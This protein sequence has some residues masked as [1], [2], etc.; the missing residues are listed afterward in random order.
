MRRFR[1]LSS[2]L[3]LLACLTVSAQGDLGSSTPEAMSHLRQARMLTAAG[4]LDGAIAA[5]RAALAA[6]PRYTEARLQ[7]ASAFRSRNQLDS[8]ISQYRRALDLY[9]RNID[10]HQY[11]AS[12]YLLQGD[13][14]S[15][16]GQYKE[17]LRHYPDYP[18]AYLGLAQVYF[19][20]EDYREAVRYSESAMR[21]YLARELDE[22][23]ASARM[24]AG[25]AYLALGDADR[26]LA[27]FKA[28]K[29]HYEGMAFYDYYL[30]L[31]YLDLGNRE[32]S[33][34]YLSSAAQKGYKLPPY[35][36]ERLDRL[37]NGN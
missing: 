28:S 24:L 18:E 29:R 31:A 5:C 1:L 19:S 13:H 4:D 3:F 8:A 6:D 10:A 15:A 2:L 17:L 25:Q 36:Q 30:G 21:L 33:S 20:Q 7:L 11:L 12:A 35:I 22:N 32:K 34:E 16:I 14:A 37:I 27:Y 23:A 9:P 26:A